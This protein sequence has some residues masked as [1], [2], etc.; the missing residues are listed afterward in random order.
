[1]T[2]LRHLLKPRSPGFSDS[3]RLKKS[4]H[5]LERTIFILGL[6]SA[7]RDQTLYAATPQGHLN[8]VP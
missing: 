4:I 1:V 3:S 8:K 7:G 2:T 6:S 5:R